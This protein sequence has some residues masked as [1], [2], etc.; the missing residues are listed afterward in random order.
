MDLSLR[1][2]HAQPRHRLRLRAALTSPLPM[3]VAA[4][5]LAAAFLVALSDLVA[6]LG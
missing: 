4:G 2:T 3:L 1:R 5:V 6:R